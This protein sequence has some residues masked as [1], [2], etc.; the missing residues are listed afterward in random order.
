MRIIINQNDGLVGVGGV[1]RAVD[2]SE[3]AGAIHA[4]HFDTVAG[5]G[6]IEYDKGVTDPVEVRDHAAEDAAWAAARAARAPENEIDIPVMRK[7]V[8]VPRAPKPFSDFAPYQIY[9]DRWAAAAPPP[10]AAPT[11]EQIEAAALAAKRAAA[12]TALQGQQLTEA[13]KDPAAP[14]AVKDYAAA[15]TQAPQALE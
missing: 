4:I 10:P 9:L 2:V 5:V 7:T 13:A 15:L 3:L 11:P 6:M 8:Q 1:F 14:Q 12:L